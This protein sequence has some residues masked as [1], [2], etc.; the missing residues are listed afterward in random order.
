MVTSGNEKGMESLKSAGGRITSIPAHTGMYMLRQP[1]NYLG[2]PSFRALDQNQ[3]FVLQVLLS[4]CLVLI[5]LQLR[6]LFTEI[7]TFQVKFL[8]QVWIG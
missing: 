4:K 6:V 7:C 8:I 3:N 5:I 2:K 1:N